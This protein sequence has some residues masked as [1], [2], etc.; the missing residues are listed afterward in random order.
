MNI[1]GINAYHENAS[2]AMVCDGRLVAAV[3]EERFTRVK[4][5]AGFP[6]QAIRYCLREAGLK[7][8]EIDHIAIPRNP[9]ARIARKVFYAVRMPSFSRRRNKANTRFATIPATLGNAFDCATEQIRARYHQVEHHQ[10]H[11]A[12]SFF[13][14]PFEEAAIFSADGLGDFA[15]CMWGTGRGSHIEV[16]GSIGFPH[17]LGIYYNAVTQYLGFVKFGE[18][19]KVMGLAAHGEPA[20]LELFRNILRFDSSGR[21][22]DFRLDLGYFTHHRDR[23]ETFWSDSSKT[24]TRNRL[25]SER[26]LRSL[27]PARQPE[28]PIGQ[29]HRNIAASLQVRL[30]EVYLGMLRNIAED[31]GQLSVCIAGGVALNC[32]AN[33]KIFDQTPFERVYVPPAP[34]DAGLAVGAAFHVWHSVLG[35]P[36][37]FVMNQA[38]WGPGYSRPEIR[39]AI[40]SSPIGQ[41]E[42]EICELPEKELA[43][44]SAAMVAQGKILGWFQ[45]RTEWGPRALGNRSI[46]ADPRR[47][48]MK[49]ILNRRVKHR[50]DFRPFAPSVL[51][52]AMGDWFHCSHA[53]PFMTIACGVRPDKA[54]WIPAPLHVDGTARLQT[55]KPE[56]NPR[57]WRLIKAF[58][59]ITGVPLVLNTSF[60][61]NEPI[62]NRPEEALD[63]FQR[64]QI[65]ALVLGDYLIIKPARQAQNGPVNARHHAFSA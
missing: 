48:E 55:V 14:S 40:E 20:Y 33:G 52:E 56:A 24:P 27:G 35:K 5:A 44:R 10:A 57:Y 54:A 37:S 21:G 15:S 1:L 63:C 42:Y 25:F 38:Y 3:E 8:S 39:Q 19:F 17:S 30:E 46:I 43:R 51:A 50:E 28:E 47:A 26:M 64:T 23:P 53:A 49:E 41:G 12:S 34:G 59:Q 6:F 31:S 22:K 7:P 65:D 13:V 60:N 45:G 58:H 9:Y 16:Q 2:A 18:E 29:R 32:V 61:D 36:R 11:L 62:V 4:Y